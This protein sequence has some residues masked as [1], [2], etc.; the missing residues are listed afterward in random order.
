M[1]NISVIVAAYNVEKYIGRCIESLI[2]QTFLNIEIIIVNDG[3]ND[4]TYKII[5]NYI[6]KDCRIRL[7]NQENRGLI[8]ARKSGFRIATGEY[9]LFVDGDDWLEL[10]ALEKLYN[11]TI[12]KKIDIILFNGYISYDDRK[13]KNYTFNI[14]Q[15]EKIK[16]CPIKE[17][18]LDNVLPGIVYKLIRKGFMVENN[19]SFPSN[20]SYAEDMALTASLFLNNPNLAFVGDHLYNYY[21]HTESITK[22]NNHRVLEINAALKFIDEQLKESNKD[23]IYIKEFE[24]LIFRHLFLGKIL[25]VDE[26]YNAKK[27]VYKQYKK[28]KIDVHKNKYIKNQINNGN[29]MYNLRV[30]A[31]CLNYQIGRLFDKARE[32]KISK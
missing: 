24:F 16:Q 7:V 26:N 1:V 20:I 6:E 18:F 30:K 4:R 8:E 22:I 5:N 27:D 29:L 17:L 12:N 11:K 15:I 23:L 2:G 13:E 19:V 10:N 31:Y 9:I 25:R 21:Q 3:S 14:D 32:F 28:W